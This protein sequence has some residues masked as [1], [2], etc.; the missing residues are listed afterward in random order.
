MSERIKYGET[1]ESLAEHITPYLSLSNVPIQTYAIS[2]Y[3]IW[4]D[5]TIT[6]YNRYE[7][8]TTQVVRWDRHIITNCFVKTSATLIAGG[9][10]TYNTSSNIVR[11]PQQNNYKPYDEWLLIPNVEQ[12]NYLTLHQGDMIILREVDDV[13]DEYTKGKRST[14]LMSTYKQQ[15]LC[16]TVD[17]FQ[18]NTGN[19]RCCPHYF[20]SGE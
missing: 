13:I 12:V 17:S 7:D 15:N 14:D 8:P 20:I 2:I 5:R 19:G 9:Q 16:L 1:Y 10:I 6:V 4:W 18:D 11:I 3:P